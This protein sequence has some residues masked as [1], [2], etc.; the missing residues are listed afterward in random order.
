MS[1]PITDTETESRDSINR[2]WYFFV[3]ARRIGRE[4]T[5]LTAA[6]GLEPTDLSYTGPVSLLEGC[7][8]TGIGH[9]VIRRS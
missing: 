5:R 9:N 8:S 1:V 6:R 2:W 4:A 7:V 3:S